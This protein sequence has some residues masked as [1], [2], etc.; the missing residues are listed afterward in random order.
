MDT[1]TTITLTPFFGRDYKSKAELL[2]DWNSDKDFTVLG[3][4]GHGMATN[5]SDSIDLGVTAVR[6]RYAKLTKVHYEELGGN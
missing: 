6:F 1:I 5:K 4:G 3:L 2:A